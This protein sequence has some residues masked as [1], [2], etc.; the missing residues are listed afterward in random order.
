M[1]L[2]TYPRCGFVT[3]VAAKGGPATDDEILMFVD[4]MAQLGFECYTEAKV[5][6]RGTL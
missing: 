3:Y 2:E 4:I 5:S 1:L 6:A